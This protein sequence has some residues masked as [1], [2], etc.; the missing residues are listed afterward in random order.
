MPERTQNTPAYNT[1]K[2][3]AKHDLSRAG[4]AA[5]TTQDTQQGRA[6]LQHRAQQVHMAILAGVSE[7]LLVMQLAHVVG[8][9]IGNR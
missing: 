8:C 9:N 6:A 2:H 1:V 5:A 7:L 4:P 3:R